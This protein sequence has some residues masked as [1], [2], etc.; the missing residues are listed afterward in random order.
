MLGEVLAFHDKA[1]VWLE[2]AVPVPVADSVV[3]EG[4]ALL[5]KVRTAL[6]DPATSG[7]NVTVKGTLCPDGMLTGSDRPPIVN[8]ELFEVAAVT[9]TSVPPAFRVPEIVTLLPTTT[10]PADNVAGVAVSCAFAVVIVPDAAAL[11]EL[12]P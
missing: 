7:L 5:A 2:A 8:R 6:S 9:V 11:A 1:T 12:N 4:C 10:S 3:V